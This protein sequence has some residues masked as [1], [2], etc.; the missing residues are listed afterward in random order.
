MKVK[1]GGGKSSDS[2]GVKESVMPSGAFRSR[3]YLLII[4]NT[5]TSTNFN[6]NLII[7][8]FLKNLITIETKKNKIK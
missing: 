5:L 8:F 1:V 7:S 6:F 2:M 3:N 4:A